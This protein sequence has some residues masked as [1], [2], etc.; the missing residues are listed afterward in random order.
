MLDDEI[1]DFLYLFSPSYEFPLLHPVSF[2][3]EYGIGRTR[4]EKGLLREKEI[5]T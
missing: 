1:Y 4:N 2:D 3:Q 5:E